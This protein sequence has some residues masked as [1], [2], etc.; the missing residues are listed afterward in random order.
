MYGRQIRGPLELIKQRFLNE[1][2]EQDIPSRLLDM[3]AN[4]LTWMADARMKK[5]QNQ[6][7]MKKNL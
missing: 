3:S 5:V 1:T 4:I 2:Q 7:K 6:V